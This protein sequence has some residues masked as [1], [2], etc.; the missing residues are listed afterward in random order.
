MRIIKLRNTNVFM[1]PRDR[2]LSSCRTH[3]LMSLTKPGQSHPITRPS[4][5][6]QLLDDFFIDTSEYSSDL[7]RLGAQQQAIGWRQLFD[8]RFSEEWSRLQDDYYVTSARH[9]HNKRLTGARWQ[10]TIIGVFWDHWDLLWAQQ[11]QNVHGADKASQTA[12]L[13]L[14][15]DRTL[16]DLYRT[17]EH[18]N[19]PVRQLMRATEEEH[20]REPM[21]VTQNW[22]AVHGQLIRDNL[23]AVQA[24]AKSGMRHIRSYFAVTENH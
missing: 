7:Q 2:T 6:T 17:K 1:E 23:R 14:D 5:V 20:R 16:A 8:A 3:G 21:W 22:I 9:K 24:R 11:N 10:T 18:L 4:F 15:V 13:R 12:A 19:E